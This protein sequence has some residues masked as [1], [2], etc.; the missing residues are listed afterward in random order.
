MSTEAPLEDSLT[1]RISSALEH[2]PHLKHRKL[3]IEASEGRVVL[4]GTVKTY[5]HKQMAQKRC[6]GWKA[7]SGSKTKWKS[8][9]RS[10][11]APTDRN[12]LAG[13]AGR[14][15]KRRTIERHPRRTIPLPIRVARLPGAVAH[16]GVF[17]R[18]IARKAGVHAACVQHRLVAVG[19]LAD[20]HQ[21]VVRVNALVEPDQLADK[22]AVEPLDVAQLEHEPV[23]ELLFEQRPHLL[24]ERYRHGGAGLRT[25]GLHEKPIGTALHL[26]IPTTTQYR[27]LGHKHFA[28]SKERERS[29]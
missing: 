16:D 2:H 24:G 23:R 7:S 21:S 14:A 17:A 19:E 8:A 12:P 11:Q 10:A 27:C 3:R 22:L 15:A 13:L 26:K 25:S 5:Y 4:R 29:A 1:T 18:A 28:P 9:G 6:G 20:A